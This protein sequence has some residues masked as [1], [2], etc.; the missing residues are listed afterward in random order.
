[1]CRLW[2]DIKLVLQELNKRVK[3]LLHGDW[4][5]RIDEL[6]RE[7]PLLGA[8]SSDSLEMRY[9]V[10]AIDEATNGNAVIVTGVG[11]HQMWAAQYYS[12][13]Q[14]TRLCRLAAR[15]RWAMRCPARWALRLARKTA[16]YGRSPVTVVS[17]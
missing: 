13:K 3:P 14:P 8:D 2:G 17:R 9:V 5:A 15:E 12:F 1:M 6:R 10:Q 7:H 16:W 11:Q 4:L